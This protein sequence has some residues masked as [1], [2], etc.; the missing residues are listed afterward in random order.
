MSIE[1]K[2]NNNEEFVPE[3][4]KNV[5]WYQIFPERFS[6]GG[7]SNNPVVGSI[8]GSWPGDHT[9]PWQ[10]HPWTSDWYRLQPYE[11]EN[12]KNIWFNIQRRR[13][14]GDLQGIINKLD[15]L[16]EFGVSALY[17][18]P[19][20][21]APSSHKYDSATYHHI[22]P[23]FGPSPGEDIK[24]IENEIPDD[25]E[26]WIWTNADK[27]AL[28]L[29]KKVHSRG[30]KIIFDGVFN[31]VGINHW[32]FKDVV[33]NQ[34]RSKYKDWFKIISWDD[35]KK[36]TKFNYKGWFG[37]KELPEWN[38]DENGLT[39]GPRGY[40][41]EITKRWMDPEGNGNIEAGIDGWR[42]DVA[43]C[44][45]HSFWKK[46]RKHVKSINP[47]AYLT[48][49]VIRPVD[50]TAPYLEGDE[51]DAVMNY[52]FAFASAEF[53]INKENRISVKEFD[54]RLHELRGAFPGGVEYVQ[55]NLLGSHDTNR[56]SSHIV[57][58]GICNFRKWEDYFE[59]S[60]GSNANY[61]TGRPDRDDIRIQMLMVIFQMTYV[62]APM[63]YYGDEAGMWGAND[64][65]CRKPMVWREFKYE[66]EAVMPD[67]SKRKEAYKVEFNEELFD[68]YKMMIEIRNNH[69]ALRL[70]DFKTLLMDEENDVYVYSRSYEN[71]II[72]V[73]L[74]N[75]DSAVKVRLDDIHQNYTD[76]LNDDKVNANNGKLVFDV[77]GKR[78][79]VLSVR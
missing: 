59:L 13:Y 15:Y 6:S 54:D 69:P 56:I 28:E 48:A 21:R 63:I 41:F 38:Q 31:H 7:T 14:G 29:I 44:I 33:K 25:P 72:I 77:E 42:L 40:V 75:S 9:S 67:Q 45:E 8:K 64:P 17:L 26:T 19:V 78:G 24:F 20:F 71:E 57:N 50:F 32:A 37:V 4:A 2:K 73:A 79:R 43:F 70:G 61:D 51:F 27:L 34:R 35:E 62:G 52:N 16:Q 11:K 53:F 22:D 1:K 36:G 66:D 12:G 39:D 30:M 3:W 18:N 68:H 74:N 65:C 49:E 55:Q 23:Y 46:W 58:K 47:D 5:V 60:K 76:L 10:V